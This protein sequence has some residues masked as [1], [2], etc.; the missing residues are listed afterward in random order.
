M[1][2]RMAAALILLLIAAT[3]SV[4]AQAPTRDAT[5]ERLQELLETTG[6]RSDVNVEF[7]RS[8]KQPYNFIG[9]MSEG[10]VNA[11]Y[12][13]IVVSVTASETI[14]FRIYPH[15]KGGYINLGKAKDGPGLMGKLLAFNDSN[16]LF[17]GA[18]TSGDVFCGYTFTLESGFPDKAITIVIRSIRNADQFVGDL[19]P[20]IGGSPTADR[21]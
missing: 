1:R 19:R 18:D 16:F 9:K 15:Y 10:V 12:L 6:K 4:L 5:R 11:D 17:W 8:T 3:P 7:R 20:F 14:G 13:E 21:K 2:L